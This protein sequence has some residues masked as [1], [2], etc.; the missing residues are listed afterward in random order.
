MSTAEVRN[1]EINLAVVCVMEV[2]VVFQAIQDGGIGANAL[3]YNI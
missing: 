2:K 1:F 3:S